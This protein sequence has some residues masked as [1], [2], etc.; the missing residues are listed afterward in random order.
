MQSYVTIKMWWAGIGKKDCSN[1]MYF[2]LK[3]IKIFDIII[4]KEKG[5]FECPKEF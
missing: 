2:K 4:K 1:K 3:C 5:G